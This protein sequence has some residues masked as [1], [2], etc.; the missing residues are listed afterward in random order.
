MRPLAAARTSVIL[1]VIGAT[2]A[3]AACSDQKPTPA[4]IRPVLSVI[5]DVRTAQ[6]LG[7]F[8]GTVEPRYTVGLGFQVF[9]RLIARDVKV[10]DV[11]T[12]GTRL[13]ALD[14]AV[15][16]I[17]VR[18]AQASLNSA[19]AQLATAAAAEERER[20][21]LEQRVIAPA[22]LELAQQH[23]E[24]AAANVTQAKDKL[25]KAQE[26]LGYTQL[27]STVDGVV[28]GRSAEVGQTVTAG[29]VVVTVARP[30][31][32]EAV[33]DVP[34]A[35]ASALPRDATFSVVWDLNPSFSATGRVREIAPE[36]DAIT[37]MRR[38]RL[39]LDKPPDVFLLGTTIR[40]S[41]TIDVPAQIDLP[42]T[43]LLERDG[44][45]M[46]WVVDPRSKTVALREVDL[47]G[48][49]PGTITVTRGLSAGERVVTAG[50][51][52]LSPGE[53]VKIPEGGA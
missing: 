49:R 47:A 42:I 11:V 37:R 24:T 22:Q 7:P 32:K 51:H 19:E 13:A 21:L 20:T 4:P 34:D 39:T 1:G 26:E 18:S 33:F 38:V 46:V 10:G 16:M 40:A 50:I 28:T 15:Q 35:I 8:A 30:D 53:Q 17:G 41:R 5:V 52:S 6:T 25:A 31:V 45:T 2:L 48:R 27:Y 29:Q 23:R 44:K 3:L 43:A 9:G 12:K 36:A 14:P